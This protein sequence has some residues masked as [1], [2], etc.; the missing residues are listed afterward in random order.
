MSMT[1]INPEKFFISNNINRCIAGN[2][3]NAEISSGQADNEAQIF[4]NIQ[5][6]FP[7]TVNQLLNTS[8]ELASLNQAQIADMIKNLLD[9]PENFEQLIRQLTP[10]GSEANSKSLL[11]LL[12]S[13]LNLSDLP[14][15]LKN[16]SKQAL[17]NL[18]KMIAQYN[19]LGVALKE[20]QLNEITKLISFVSSSSNSDVQ[21]LRT[22][23][24]MYLPWLPLTEQTAFRLE[25]KDKS[26]SS[27]NS[28]GS[29]N[30]LIMTKNYGNLQALIYKT[31]KDEIRIDVISSET[32]PFKRLSSLMNEKNRL[33]GININ[34][35]F[36]IKKSFNK[37]KNEQIKIEMR[38]NM[39]T[40][41]NPF[42][43][44]ISNDFIKNVCLIDEKSSLAE[45]RKERMRSGKS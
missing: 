19:Q 11:F 41:V 40:G 38:I 28:G 30:I 36:D 26:S 10:A 8:N 13:G 39:N 45:Q 5:N 2:I 37:Q 23:M 25:I 14:L 17:S 18:Y 42:L 27:S 6:R 31:E 15:L 34:I 22:I 16:S 32:F 33:S 20:N 24:L 12:N 43:M 7:N 9:M 35:D 21:S 29:I 4:S 44:L 1:N 3:Q